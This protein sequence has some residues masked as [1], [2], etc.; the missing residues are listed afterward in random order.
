MDTPTLKADADQTGGG[1]LGA[2]KDPDKISLGQHII[3]TG[4]FVQIFAFATFVAVSVIFYRK[5]TQ[6]PTIASVSPTNPWK[7]HLYI[8]FATS[9]LIFIRCIFRV[10]MYIQG[11]DGSISSSEVL[12]YIFDSCFIFTVMVSFNIVHPSEVRAMLHGE[13]RIAW[14]G[15]YQGPK[16]PSQPGP[17]GFSL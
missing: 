4:I 5:I 6:R 7:K 12:F 17:D 8:L 14:R 15:R 11:E 10:I 3:E 9:F 13:G 16:L 1:I 2:A